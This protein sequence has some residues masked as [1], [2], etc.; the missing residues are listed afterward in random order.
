MSKLRM[1]YQCLKTCGDLLI[2]ARGSSI[3]TFNIENRTLAST[4]KCPT[5][6]EPKTNITVQ[7]EQAVA[8]LP[9]VIE[10][11]TEQSTPPAKRRKL[12]FSDE[13]EKSKQKNGK[14]KNH[15]S[16]A[17]STG[18]EA[19]A[20]IALTATKEG[21]H[22]IA[23]TGEDKSIRVFENIFQQD[24]KHALKQISQR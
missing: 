7:E 9:A 14:G 8:S 15:R 6:Q 22:V 21:R 3:D 20:V 11:V 4:W 24:S 1:P 18:L 17:L 16:D 10:P 12:S 13:P 2:A 5:T 19:P 23:V